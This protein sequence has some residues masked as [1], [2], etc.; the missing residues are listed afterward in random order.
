MILDRVP[1]T[2]TMGYVDHQKL[3]LRKWVCPK[4]PYKTARLAQVFRLYATGYSKGRY[5]TCA[6][7]VGHGLDLGC[8]RH[9]QDDDFHF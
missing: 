8:N 4:K 7:E 1:R 3:R 5:A 2:H 6:C 9:H